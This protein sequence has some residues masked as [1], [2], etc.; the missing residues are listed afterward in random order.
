MLK[1][2]KFILGSMQT[3][4]YFLIDTD[5]S[6]AIVVDPADECEFIEEKL[7]TKN[8]TLKYIVLTHAHFDHMLALEKLRED[9]K[10]PLAI[11][12]FDAPALLDP[13]ISLMARF[14]GVYFP[15]KEAEILLGEGDLLHLGSSEIK[16]MHTPGHTPG[17][18]CLINGENIISG[19]T[20]FR[21]SIGRHDFPGGDYVSL[22]SSL[23]RLASV[24]GDYKVHPGHGAST[25]LSHERTNN[26]YL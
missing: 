9:T 19:D 15:C 1:V 16:V 10:A 17:S 11:H 6:E 23:K 7:E 20:L 2:L 24:E 4:C 18:I 5:T 21:E 12:K 8:L 25:T 13:E 3:N 14:A 22:M 26:L